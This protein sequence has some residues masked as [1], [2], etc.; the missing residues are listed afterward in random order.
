[1]I[2]DDRFEENI[3][4]GVQIRLGIVAEDCCLWSLGGGVEQADVA[5]WQ[6]AELLDENKQVPAS[7]GGPSP[8]QAVEQRST[9][10]DSL[11]AGTRTSV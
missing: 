9:V 3:R 8:C 10:L 4:F 11:R 2:A 5:Y 7:S 1:V 6:P